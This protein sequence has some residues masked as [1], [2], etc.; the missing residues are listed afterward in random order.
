MDVA[1]HFSLEISG[2]WGDSRDLTAPPLLEET[3][4]CNPFNG[5]FEN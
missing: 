3:E 2:C 5:T 4:A 1:G